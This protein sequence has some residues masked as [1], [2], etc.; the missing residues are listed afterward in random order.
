L[1]V[2]LLQLDG[3]LPNIALMRIAAH[4]RSYGDD[5]SFQHCPTVRAVE[6][7]DWHRFDRMYASLIFERARPVGAVQ[8]VRAMNSAPSFRFTEVAA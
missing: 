2:L 4:R 5:I 7:S 3:K 6:Q 1:K 8:S